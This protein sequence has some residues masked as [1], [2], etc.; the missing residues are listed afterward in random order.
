LGGPRRGTATLVKAGESAKFEQAHT[1][2]R[3]MPRA[4]YALLDRLLAEIGYHDETEAA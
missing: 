2:V 1:C 3:H 4:A